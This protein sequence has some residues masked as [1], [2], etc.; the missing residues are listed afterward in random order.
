IIWVYNRKCF[1]TENIRTIVTDHIISQVKR[2]MMK[3]FPIVPQ[4]IYIGMVEVKYGISWRGRGYH[5][6]R[7]PSMGSRMRC[8]PFKV[9][10]KFKKISL[11]HQVGYITW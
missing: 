6:T 5:C 8:L 11:K 7:D 3:L 4:F 10:R 1:S 9:I 2:G